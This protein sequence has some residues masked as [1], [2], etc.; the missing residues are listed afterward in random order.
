MAGIGTIELKLQ[1]AKDSDAGT[2]GW[3]YLGIAGREFH[4]ETSDNDFEPGAA[5]TYVFGENANVLDPERND[6]GAPRISTDDLDRFPAYIR[7]EPRNNDDAWCLDEVSVVVNP[8]SE[9]PHRFSNPAV[10]GAAEHRKVWL[11]QKTGKSIHL[12][13]Y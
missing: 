4:V 9:L 6:P 5:Y 1:T 13:R 12:R 3:V 11:G 2:D 10:I 8:A 7:F